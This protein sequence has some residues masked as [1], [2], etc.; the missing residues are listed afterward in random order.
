MAKVKKLPSGAYHTQLYIGKDE[1]GKRKYK[2]ITADSPKEVRRLAAL[3]EIEKD[4]LAKPEGLTL[5]VA[6]YNYTKNR[7]NILSPTTIQSYNYI[8]NKLMTPLLP[9]PVYN[10][11]N[12][13]IQNHVNALSANHSPKTVLNAYFS[14]QAI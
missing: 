14:K 8:K 12:D 4:K 5:G 11:T 13:I 7:I 10:L 1:T 9:I 2:S 6:M 3:F